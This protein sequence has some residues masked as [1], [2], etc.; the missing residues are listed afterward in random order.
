M[1]ADTGT[2]TFTDAVFLNKPKL[3]TRR[4]HLTERGV[5]TEWPVTGDE[6]RLLIDTAPRINL[7]TITLSEEVRRRKTAT[8][9]KATFTGCFRKGETRGTDSRLVV[10]PNV[11]C[12]DAG[13]FTAIKT[14]SVTY[15]TS[16]QFI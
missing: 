11:L 14:H 3:G 16:T 5:A 2:Q 12:I 13:A 8:Y 6:N 7:G 9:G 10:A 1:S 15:L 4:R